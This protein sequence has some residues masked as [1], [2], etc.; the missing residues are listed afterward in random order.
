MDWISDAVNLFLDRLDR[1][2]DAVER[3]ADALEEPTT[4]EPP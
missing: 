1:L 2:C 4:E 3:V